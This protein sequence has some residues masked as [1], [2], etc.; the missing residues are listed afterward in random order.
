MTPVYIL[1]NPE[2]TT[3]TKKCLP[4]C[5]GVKYLFQIKDNV[6]GVNLLINSKI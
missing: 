3:K 4:L 2:S 1:G 6:D 5:S